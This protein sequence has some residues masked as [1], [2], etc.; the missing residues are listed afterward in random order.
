MNSKSKLLLIIAVFST[1]IANAQNKHGKVGKNTSYKGL[2]MAEYQGWFR[3]P[4]DGSGK[5]W[6]HYGR[7]GKCDKDHNT[8][9][10]WP[11]VTDYEKVYKTSFKHVD[12]KAAY[13]F[14]SVDKSTTDLHFKWM[15]EY[16]VDGVFM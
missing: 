3:A 15:Q 5:D 12:G 1:L 11:D 16:G 14:S 13:V 6:G 8:I 4:G 7:D 10:F 2:V 9:D